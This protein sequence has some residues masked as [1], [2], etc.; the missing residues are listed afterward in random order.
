[1]Q[2]GEVDRLWRNARLATM[3]GE[4]LGVVERGAVAAKDG[5]IAFAGPEAEMPALAA[6]ETVDC[7]PGRDRAVVDAVDRVRRC[8][9]VN[10]R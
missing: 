8:E 3:A 10:R 1:M 6:R 4:G 9:V 2:G 7:G 5:R